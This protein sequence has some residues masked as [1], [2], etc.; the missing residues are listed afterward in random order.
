[1]RDTP[2]SGCPHP[3]IAASILDPAVWESVSEVLRDPTIIARAVAEHRTDSGLERELAAMDK[4]LQTIVS[5]Q[6]HIAKAIPTLDDEDAVAPLLVELQ[7]LAASK[8]ATERECD[9]VRQRIADAEAEAANVRTLSEWCSRVGTNLDTLTYDERRLALDAL[10]VKV[11][12]YRNGATDEAREPLPRWTLMLTPVSA[13]NDI[14]YG[15][16]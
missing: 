8:T 14:A 3:S 1:V 7:N 10:G 6:Q 13:T 4:R 12:V 9:L 5:K 16:A 2:D 11:R 15:S